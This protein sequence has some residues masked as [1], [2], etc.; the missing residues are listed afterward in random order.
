MVPQL[1]QRFADAVHI[2]IGDGPIKHRLSHAYSAHLADLADAEFPLSLQP[3]FA[4][5]Q[6]ALNRIAPAGTETRIR[7]SVQKMSPHEASRHAATILKLYVDLA[8]GLERAEPLK[9]VATSA[10]K[11]PLY[12]TNR[13]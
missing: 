1:T 4:V 12:L 13:P 6:T 3:D 2:L 8:N 10:Q 7:A 11:T 5:L 9:V